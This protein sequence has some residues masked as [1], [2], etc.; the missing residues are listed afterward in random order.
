[1]LALCN[2][3]GRCLLDEDMRLGCRTCAK[4]AAL[5]EELD[6]LRQHRD[7]HLPTCN[8]SD[9]ANQT[10]A[11]GYLDGTA[12]RKLERCADILRRSFEEVLDADEVRAL[13]EEAVDALTALDPTWLLRRAAAEGGVR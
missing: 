10:C 8:G 9:P 1:M 3:C 12:Y 2:A 7:G 6:A 11:C 4:L 5:R 13:G